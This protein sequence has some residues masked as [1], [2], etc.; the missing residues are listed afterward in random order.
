MCFAGAVNLAHAN[1]TSIF[2]KLAKQGFRHISN[3]AIDENNVKRALFGLP[4][5]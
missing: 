1:Q 2:C 5:I 4:F 3:A